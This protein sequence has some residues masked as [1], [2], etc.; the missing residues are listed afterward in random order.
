MY[1]SDGVHPFIKI[2][3]ALVSHHKVPV[4]FKPTWKLPKNFDIKF[5]LRDEQPTLVHLF[6]ERLKLPIGFYGG[7]LQSPTGSGK[8]VMG[9]YKIKNLGLTTLI[10]VPTDK[11]MSQWKDKLIEFTSLTKDDIGIVRQNICEFWGKPIVIGMLHSLA[12]KDDYPKELYDYAGLVIYDEVHTTPTEVLGKVLPKFNSKY[13]IG[14]SATPLRKDG[15]SKVIVS[16]I[17]KILVKSEAKHSKP[18]V[19]LYPYGGRDTNQDGC[20]W[21]GELSLGR[22][23]NKLAN[24]SRRTELVSS[25]IQ[26]FYNNGHT[27][28]ALSDRISLLE[29][30]KSHLL[31]D[32]G[33]PE[34][35]VGLFTGKIKE[36]EDRIILATYGSAGLGYDN[37]AITALVFCTP[38]VNI[39][40]PLGRSTR[41]KG[42]TPII[43]DIVDTASS[44]MRNWAKAR[45]KKYKQLN[46]VVVDKALL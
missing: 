24:S 26:Q 33:V 27:V 19:I 21:G 31:N 3:R 28:L 7:I 32:G 15:L 17:G 40:Q 14:Y 37:P 29:N 36:P 23:L 44:F 20:V 10:V 8:S 38:R 41:K 12:M 25:I 5:S 46:A 2:P 6:L 4:A 30:I 39:E 1:S 9:I 43:V 18:K 13:R 35:E 45:K 34:N 22:Y 16:H 42:S 11:L